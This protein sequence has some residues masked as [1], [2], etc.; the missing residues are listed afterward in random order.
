M[1]IFCLFSWFRYLGGSSDS[2]TLNFSRPASGPYVREYYA[3]INAYQYH[4]SNEAGLL[5][6]DFHSHPRILQIVEVGQ[7]G[8]HAKGRKPDANYSVLE[9]FHR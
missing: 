8:I 1:L 3:C 9:T 2:L 4:V 7:R 6:I 5:R